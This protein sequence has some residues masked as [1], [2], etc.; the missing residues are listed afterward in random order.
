MGILKIKCK[1]EIKSSQMDRFRT[2]LSI[3]KIP[4]PPTEKIESVGVF[5][6]I[7]NNSTTTI[8]GETL[9][10]KTA[11]IFHLQQLHPLFNS[12][13]KNRIR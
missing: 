1:P 10:S 13:I 11:Q 8:D 7:A 5:L 2:Q 9:D 6:P 12:A 3:N 4:F